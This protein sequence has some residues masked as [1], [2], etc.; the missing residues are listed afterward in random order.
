[1]SLSLAV[2]SACYDAAA[3][4]RTESTTS[5]VMGNSVQLILSM[6]LTVCKQSR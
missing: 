6:L 3:S 1:M 5:F 2:P 4:L